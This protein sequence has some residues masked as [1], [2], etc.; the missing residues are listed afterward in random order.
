MPHKV[1]GSIANKSRSVWAN[2]GNRRKVGKPV[3]GIA[4]D[5]AQREAVCATN[6]DAVMH[7]A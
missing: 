7:Q 1:Y 4:R 5:K 3:V 2:K 6:T